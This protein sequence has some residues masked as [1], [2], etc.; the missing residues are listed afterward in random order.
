MEDVNVTQRPAVSPSPVLRKLS[1][2][3]LTF[4]PCV[5]GAR[6]RACR[7]RPRGAVLQPGAGKLAVVL[8]HPALLPGPVPAAV[9]Q[10][11]AALLLAQNCRNCQCEL[12]YVRLTFDLTESGGCPTA[13]G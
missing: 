11:G 5:A 4:S 7:A 12:R 3:F 13:H 6:R 9:L 10:G 8:R 1:A 2:L